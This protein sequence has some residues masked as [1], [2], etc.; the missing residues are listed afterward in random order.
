MLD[1][2]YIR[3]NSKVVEKAAASKGVSINIA[4]LLDLDKKRVS[5]IEKRD[6]MRSAR[7]FEGKPS[8]A[9]IAKVKKDNTGL[10]KVEADLLK[11]E[12]KW[13]TLMLSIPNPPLKDVTIG[14]G[15]ADNKVV[16]KVGKPTKLGFKAKDHIEL[17]D[18]DELIDLRRGAKVSGSRFA[19]LKG[20]VA[21]LELALINYTFD[22]LIKEGLIPT[23]PPVLV[24]AE[25]MAAMGYL[26]HGGEDET[27]HFEKDDLYLVGTSEQSIGPMHKD[28]T[29]TETDLPLR[30]AAF[31]TCFRR[32]AGSYGKDTKGI[33]R[34]HQFDKI[35][36][37]SFVAPNASEKEHNFLL[38]LEERIVAGL[39][40]P[41]QVVDICSGDLGAPAAKKWDIET[42]MP[43]QDKYRET[44]STSN[45]TDFQA[46][47]LGI[48]FRKSDGTKEYVHTLNGTAVAIGRMIIAI[49]ENNQT[50]DGTV[51]VPD[52]LVKYTGFKE[53]K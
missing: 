6:T 42:W 49:L 10:L 37:F 11:I 5:L 3:E 48:K 31:S 7:K 21:Q 53:I 29:F 44:H 24:S 12:E 25:S 41:Y 4:T 28:E 32:E 17:T 39:K 45:C 30:Y 27:Y 13:M 35:E 50:K 47:R 34:V 33:L 9:E 8:A 40:L 18:T 2:K 46:R 15:E 26:E 1:I 23:F 19:Y 52:A 36:M 38:S 16:R 51:I 43:S 22:I 14:D 20:R